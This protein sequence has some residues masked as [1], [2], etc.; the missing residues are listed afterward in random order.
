MMICNHVRSIRAGIR[1]T[2]PRPFICGI[3]TTYKEKG[4]AEA[5]PHNPIGHKT[6]PM[7]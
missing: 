5:S 6:S 2:Y 4:E 1:E 3:Y 7:P